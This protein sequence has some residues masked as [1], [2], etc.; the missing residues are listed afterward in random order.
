M[1]FSDELQQVVDKMKTDKE[2]DHN[3]YITRLLKVV[4][5]LH[6]QRVIMDSTKP[7]KIYPTVKYLKKNELEIRVKLP[8]PMT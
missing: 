5:L 4:S 6:D 7:V 3:H 1:V 8:D 2:Y